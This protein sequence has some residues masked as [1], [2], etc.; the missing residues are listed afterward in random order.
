MMTLGDYLK[1]AEAE[2]AKSEEIAAPVLEQPAQGIPATAKL[3]W[4]WRSGG[5][6]RA[7]APVLS[8][9]ITSQ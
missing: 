6:R 4:A 2:A 5:S 9:A 7:D 1:A 3:W 8:A